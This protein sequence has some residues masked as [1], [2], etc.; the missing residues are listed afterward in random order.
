MTSN[1]KNTRTHIFEVFPPE[2][3][4]EDNPSPIPPWAGCS[5]AAFPRDSSVSIRRV[6]WSCRWHGR[7]NGVRRPAFF[8]FTCQLTPKLIYEMI[9]R[10]TR[11]LK[12][13]GAGERRRAG[14]S[15]PQSELNREASLTCCLLYSVWTFETQLITYVIFL[16]SIHEDRYRIEYLR[17]IRNSFIDSAEIESMRSEDDY[18]DPALTCR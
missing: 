13:W 10:W 4:T 3:E 8:P 5:F 2:F 9:H 17:Q 11:Y 1:A 18:F 14:A 12:S 15:T 7:R 16:F 6:W